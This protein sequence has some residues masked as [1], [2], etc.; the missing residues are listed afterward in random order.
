MPTISDVLREKGAEVATISPGHTLK[1]AI[2]ELIDRKIGSLLVTDDAGEVAGIITERDILRVVHTQPAELEELKV[3]DHMTGDVLC[4]VPE[5]DLDYVMSIMT[6]KRFRRL[7]VVSK[8]GKIV[9][10]VS[11]G[12]VVKALKSATEYEVR[13]LQ[14]YISGAYG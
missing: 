3:G 4:G 13:Q 14:S 11:I 9:G 12:D 1:Q 2:S 8:D 7:P 6:K 5:D 10:I